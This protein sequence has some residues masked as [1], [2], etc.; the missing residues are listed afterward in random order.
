MDFD[1][2]IEA[3]GQDVRRRVKSKR[4]RDQQNQGWLGTYVLAGEITVAPEVF[5]FL[6]VPNSQPI[7]NRLH[8]QMDIFAGL[9][10]DDHQPAVASNTQEIH[11]AA[12]SWRNRGNSSIEEPRIDTSINPCSIRDHQ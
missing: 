6:M 9:E 7:V 3:P 8:Q 4:W 5:L 10:L 1:I 2:T 11:D 12:I